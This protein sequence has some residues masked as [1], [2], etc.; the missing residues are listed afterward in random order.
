MFSKFSVKKPM[1]VFVAVIIVIILGVVSFTNMTPDLLPNMDFPY[2]VVMTTYPGASPEEVETTVTKPMEQSMATL[3]KIEDVSSTSAENYSMIV[4]QFSDDTNMDAATI[5]IREKID[6]IKGGWNERVG[7]PYMLKINPDVMPV[8][9]AAVDR[10][11]LDV[12]ELSSFVENSITPKLEGIEGVASVNA[13]GL[14]DQKV[15]VMLS[16]E[17]ID[18]VN[19]KYRPR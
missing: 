4:L 17:K 2:V 11:G 7:T 19:K 5:N 3:E 12:K 15:N 18:A 9:V 6:L 10:D 1:T 8:S 14:I 13:G 16:Q